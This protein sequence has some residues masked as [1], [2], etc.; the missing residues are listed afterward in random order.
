MYRYI[1]LIWNTLNPQAAETIRTI[2][3]CLSGQGSSWCLAVDIDGLLV[4]DTQG[5]PDGLRAYG[6]SRNGGAIVGKPFKRNEVETAEFSPVVF[7]DRETNKI[8]ETEGQ[9]LIDNYWGQYVAF[10]RDQDH[11]FF[12]VLRDPTA[13]LMCF[14][15][16]HRGVD[17]FFSSVND[18]A[19][20]GLPRFSTN[21][22]FVARHLS[23]SA[24]RVAATALNEVTE[25]LAG[26]R[27]RIQ[28]QGRSSEFCWAPQ[29]AACSYLIEAPKEAAK[30]LRRTIYG[31][32][33]AWASSY[34]T[35]IL[36]LSGGLDSS[37]LLSCLKRLPNRPEVI[38]LNFFTPDK[39]GDE[40]EFARMA[41]RSA[42]CELVEQILD[43]RD[44]DIRGVLQV[45]R[46]TKPSTLAFTFAAPYQKTFGRLGRERNAD[47]FF[48]GTGGDHLFHQMRSNLV[49]AD[50]AY[51]HGL[52]PR[53]LNVAYDVA[54]LTRESIWSVFGSA[55]KYGVLRRPSRPYSSSRDG[56][57]FLSDDALEMLD[58]EQSL[59]P[60]LKRSRNVPPGKALMV[61]HLL[62][63]QRQFWVVQRSENAD[64]IYP[65][66]S[67]PLI[68]LCLAIPNYV[69]TL[70][71][72]ERGLVRRAFA[73][74]IP[75]QVAERHS[76]GNNSQLFNKLFEEN[77][78]FL[79]DFLLDGEL[80]RQGLLNREVLER[81][82]NSKD[83]FRGDELGNLMQ[84]VSTEAWA[85]SWSDVQCRAA[86]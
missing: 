5:R 35:I 83:L 64:T 23:N 32:T 60:W 33:A 31:C 1:A 57:T 22:E 68:E 29:P 10:L 76:K 14:S 38:C 9:H 47:G 56:T 21:W 85:R 44:A 73:D 53:L 50:F 36:E 65:L 8:L 11:R 42:G 84:C 37:I 82:L 2:R 75:H 62:E 24:S 48:T 12:S 17:I 43:P 41:A 45:P 13:A 34:R 51:R 7:G 25:I 18:A 74:D 15:T 66:V 58:F 54:R 16:H 71:G 46:L 19:R 55:F 67:Q 52:H 30:R 69:L 4:F 86:A 80:S 61:Q 28:D 81:H 39:K 77:R 70:R 20:I 59:H 40:R 26:Q 49:A 78:S 6:L 63:L 72:R 79:K 27:V 3:T